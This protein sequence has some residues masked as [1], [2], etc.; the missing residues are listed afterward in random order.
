METSGQQHALFRQYPLTGECTI[1]VGSVPIP[2][3][4]Y[5]GWALLIGGTARLESVQALLAGE[6]LA[7][8]TTTGAMVLEKR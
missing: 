8:L 5:D 2:Y 6:A 7:P 1:S 3:H 4:V